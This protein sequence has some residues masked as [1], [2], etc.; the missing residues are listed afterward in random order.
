MQTRRQLLNRT[1]LGAAGVY[2]STFLNQLDAA[3]PVRRPRRFVFFLQGNGLYPEEIQPERIELPERGGDDL[4]D[5]PLKDFELPEAISPLEPFKDRLTIVQDLSSG[6]AK[7]AHSTYFS[8]L[9]CYPCR[10]ALDE[11]IDWALA[12]QSPGIFP[13]VGLGVTVNPSKAIVYN[14]SASG[15]NKK[16]PTQCQPALV[17]RRLFGFALAGQQ[18]EAFDM[19]TNVLDFLA[20]DVKRL[21]GKL[22]STERQ[23]LEYY[24]NAYESMSSR[25]SVLRRITP[26]LT[27]HVPRPNE[28]YA[29]QVN[30]FDRL[31]AQ[32]EIAA[33]SLIGGLSNVVTISSCSGEFS[34]SLDGAQLGLPPG[35]I[36]LHK[37]GHGGGYGDKTSRELYVA[38]RKRHMQY[39]AAFLKKLEA[40]P[41][42]DGTM[43]DNTVVAYT[44]DHGGSHH[45]NNKRW[46][47]LL[48]GDL[49]GRL[50]TRGRYL[51]YPGYQKRGHR[52]VANLYTSL[53][54]M[55]GDNRQR[56]GMADVSDGMRAINQDGPLDEIHA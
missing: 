54:R 38:I 24:L 21:Q 1:A 43:L 8:C 56:F 26:T 18:R 42:G 19:R 50:A 35:N 48:I 44:S 45:N 39:L 23:K 25:Q 16:L 17:H 4:E 20:D 15:R 9:G 22:N 5:R 37:V 6:V 11:T 12:R 7:D 13:H 14:V 33:A 3:T 41:E 32:F 52:T 36:N 27:P 47:F 10:G 28:N 51:R 2:F 55:V 30:W 46:P 40:I 53:L 34:G 29:P 31:E 49:G